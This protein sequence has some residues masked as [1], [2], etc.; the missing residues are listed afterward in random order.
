ME[1]GHEWENLAFPVASLSLIFFSLIFRLVSKLDKEIMT[2][3]HNIPASTSSDVK[4]IQEGGEV[5]SPG[6][7]VTAQAP[8]PPKIAHELGRLLRERQALIQPVTLLLP[9]SS[10]LRTGN[11]TSTRD[12]LPPVPE[13][14]SRIRPKI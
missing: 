1:S 7:S 8:M 6:N 12:A 5:P 14:A 13:A 4:Q 2:L 11:Y 10:D 9:A 3:M